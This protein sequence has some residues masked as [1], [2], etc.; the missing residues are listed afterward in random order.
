MITKL[1]TAEKLGE[2]PPRQKPIPRWVN[3]L[4]S[5][6]KVMYIVQEKD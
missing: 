6:S 4:E 2:Y 1:V 5:A 3:A